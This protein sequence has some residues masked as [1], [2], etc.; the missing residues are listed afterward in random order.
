MKI[1][2]MDDWSKTV[3]AS[4]E[5]PKEVV[6]SWNGEY[7]IKDSIIFSG[8]EKQNFYVVSADPAL[9]EA[10]IFADTDT[11]VYNIPYY[12]G[13][14]SYYPLVFTGN[15]HL[16]RIRKVYEFE[17]NNYRN[18]ALNPFDQK[19]VSGVYPHAYDNLGDDKPTMFAAQNAIDGCIATTNHGEWPFGSWGISRRDDA[20]LTVDFGRPVDISEIKLYTRADFPHDNYWV[21]GVLTFSDGE[22][23]SISM[24]KKVQEPHI[25]QTPKKGVTSVSLGQLIM[26]DEPALFPALTQIEV[27]G[28]NAN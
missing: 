16:I 7:R 22:S 19:T 4:A 1:E 2:V 20:L 13:K 11:I 25:F 3:K 6:L 28:R 24:D 23:I 27:W 17:N 12:E 18:L 8:L 26:S 5:G 15:R 9:G 10:Y 21:S 14:E